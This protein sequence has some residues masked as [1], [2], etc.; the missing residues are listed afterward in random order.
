[1]HGHSSARKQQVFCEY[2]AELF[3]EAASALQL[4]YIFQINYSNTTCQ[5]KV[6]P[7]KWLEDSSK[8]IFSYV[9]V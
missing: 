3:L 5:I 1:M 2:E 6:Y 4:G 9:E 8:H 7:A